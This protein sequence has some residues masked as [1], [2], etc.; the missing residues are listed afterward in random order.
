MGRVPEELPHA[1]MR[2]DRVRD[3]AARGERGHQ[4][5]EVREAKEQVDL[6][7]LGRELCAIALDQAP[8]RDDGLDAA[9]SLESR[10]IEHRV[11]RLLFRRVDEPAGVDEDDVGVRQVRRHDRAVT[12]QLTDQPLRVDGRLVTAEGDDAQFHP[13]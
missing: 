5:V 6:G 10:R 8:H 1:R 7:D 2:G 11:D 4:V 3:Q 9:R 13:R 12:H